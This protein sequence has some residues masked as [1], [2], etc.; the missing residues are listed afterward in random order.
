MWRNIKEK[1]FFF[2]FFFWKAPISWNRH[3]TWR[4]HWMA[5][6]PSD[7]CVKPGKTV[8]N[9][10]SYDKRQETVG[11]GSDEELGS[12]TFSSS[13]FSPLLY[14]QPRKKRS[15]TRH[16]YLPTPN[17]LLNSFHNCHLWLVIGDSHDGQI[18]VCCLVAMEIRSR[19]S[20]VANRSQNVPVGWGRPRQTRLG[21]VHV[22]DYRRGTFILY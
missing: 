19:T 15:P 20:S 7:R 16:K 2:F 10:S 21:H 12:C 18:Y 4:S 13:R 22:H 5:T 11:V 6:I 9:K 17:E 14:K 8:T 1:E 3:H